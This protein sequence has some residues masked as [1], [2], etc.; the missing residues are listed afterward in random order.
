[1]SEP[2]KSW[3]AGEQCNADDLNKNFSETINDHRDFTYGEAIDGSTTPVPIYISTDGKVY[4]CQADSLSKI[5][6]DGFAV[7]NKSADQSG[8]VQMR[9]KISGF[10]L[11]LSGSQTETLDQQNM[12][13]AG[14]NCYSVYGSTTNRAGQV[15]T[16]SKDVSNITKVDLYLKRI[17]LAATIGNVTASIYAVDKNGLPTG[18]AIV[19]VAVD[20]ATIGTSFGW[21]TFDLA[22]TAI[23]LNQQYMI[24]LSTAGG[25]GSNYI[26]WSAVSTTTDGYNNGWTWKGDNTLYSCGDCD[27][28]TYFTAKTYATVGDKIWLSNTAGVLTL[29]ETAPTYKAP[30]GIVLSAS[31]ILFEKPT[32]KNIPIADLGVG[33]ITQSINGLNDDG[34]GAART[35]NA[36]IVIPK[37]T[38]KII[39]YANNRVA[40]GRGS[41]AQ[42]Y[43]DRFCTKARSENLS[44]AAGEFNYISA[45]LQ[46]QRIVKITVYTGAAVSGLGDFEVWCYE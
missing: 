28:K 34:G 9:G 36:Y 15:F 5:R 46:S 35:T 17:G 29:D 45:E 12:A 40:S 39:I 7:E 10:S 41:R 30:V 21:I 27:F 16:P 13:G 11:T 42:L 26:Q 1:M 19:S 25:D 8:K 44:S 3:V 43:L 4:K 33:D 22:D 23:N 6:C 20:S 31:V 24:V 18:S 2:T 32:L 37:K 14:G 38:Q